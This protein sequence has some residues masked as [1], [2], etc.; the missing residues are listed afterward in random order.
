MTSTKLS[1][2]ASAETATCQSRREALKRFGR[3]AAM[4]PTTML[5]LSPRSAG[6]DHRGWHNPPNPGGASGKNGGGYGE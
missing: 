2:G 6:A 5:L 1:E 3:Y 4:A